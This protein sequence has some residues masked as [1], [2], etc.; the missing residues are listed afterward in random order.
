MDASR[1]LG[2][3]FR[4]LSQLITQIMDRKFDALGLTGAQSMVLR[5]I[6][7][8]EDPVIYPKDIEKRFN[9]THPTV[10]GILQRLE[11]KQFITCLPDPDDRRCKRITLTEK[12]H[13]CQKELCRSF[14]VL[15][16][17]MLEGM[18]EEDQQTLLRLLQ[19]AT[20]NLTAINN[21]EEP[22]L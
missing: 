16:D 20:D 3:R 6:G 17:A 18:T 8:A 9:L 22:G 4:Q 10:S 19:L 11:S 12:A 13:Q 21:K 7:Q 5:Y 1:H 2:P 14:I 15:E